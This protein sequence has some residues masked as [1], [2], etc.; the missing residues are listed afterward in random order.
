[1]TYRRKTDSQYSRKPRGWV[2]G[3]T[4]RGKYRVLGA[5]SRHVP[6]G[7]ES[8]D[9]VVP[10]DTQKNVEIPLGCEFKRYDFKRIGKEDRLVVKVPR[11]SI[12][13]FEVEG[14]D[15]TEFLRP[16]PPRRSTP[17]TASE[18]DKQRGIIRKALK[19]L[20]PTLSV[21]RGKG[22]AYSWID[23]SGSGDEFGTFTEKEKQALDKFSLDYGMN[24]AVISPENRKWYVEKAEKILRGE[25]P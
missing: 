12:G 11:E 5:D 6:K 3:Y 17:R 18:Y 2:I 13:M 25:V 8:L 24:A 10:L 15:T 7:A 19:K 20:C 4:Y 14:L 1:M 16:A 23:V 22:T 21:R 9:L